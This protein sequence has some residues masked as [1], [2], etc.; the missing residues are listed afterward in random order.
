MQHEAGTGR[1]DREES[2]LMAIA[3]TS[4]TALSLITANAATTP[5]T[6]IKPRRR[7]G[8]FR[9]DVSRHE[10]LAC[11]PTAAQA[12]VPRPWERTEI[13]GDGRQS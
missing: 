7:V 5:A 8:G 1:S 2:G 4:S 11:S 10:G 6:H 12:D 3:P 9:P 13:V